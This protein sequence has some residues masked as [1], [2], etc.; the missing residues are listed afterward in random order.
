[1]RVCFLTSTYPKRA[2]DEI[3]GFVADLAEQLVAGHNCEVHVLAPGDGDVPAEDWINGVHVH[4]FQYA[5][6]ARR[7]CL[8]YGDGI[9]DN[10]RNRPRAKFQIPGWALSM[11]LKSMHWA[12][13]CDLIHAHWIE[14]GFIAAL[15]KR[16]LAR[17]MVLTVHSIRARCRSRFVYRAAFGAADMVFF[18]SRH[19]QTIARDLGLT[20]NGRVIYQ[21]FDDDRFN[22]HVGQDHWR[23]RL[24]IPHGAPVVLALGR[25][26]ELKGFHVLLE[27]WPTVRQRCP[28]AH[29]VLA[30][31]GPEMPRLR[32]RINALGVGA[33]V[34]LPG[35]IAKTDVPSLM[36]GATVFCAPGVV[37][38]RGRSDALGVVIIEAMASGLPCVGSRIGGI[39]ETIVDGRT[40]TLVE[41]GD[42]AGLADALTGVLSDPQT[43]EQMGTL[44]R[45]QAREA[46]S[47]R[48]IA[49]ETFDAYCNLRDGDGL[50]TYVQDVP[51][52]VTKAAL[53]R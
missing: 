22:G 35:R 45:Q 16:W 32:D 39:P 26:I 48:K 51:A 2:G 8:S 37:D 43:A 17:P 11:A 38:S 40:G 7:Q 47:W 14:P 52:A 28:S 20:C 33:S 18:N 46:F 19:T 6:P 50:G 13:K 21:G 25:M 53:R 24:D 29:L 3:P 42:Q 9:P 10:V 41:P 31:D 4:R 30:G 49:A 15:A 44:G 23:R 5:W 1:M 12:R 34:R 36:A 27:A